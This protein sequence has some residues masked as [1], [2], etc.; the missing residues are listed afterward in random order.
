[1]I[2]KRLGPLGL[3]L[4]LFFL[5]MLMIGPLSEWW[6]KSYIKAGVIETA[7]E[8]PI[9]SLFGGTLLQSAA[10]KDPHVHVVPIYGSSEFGHGGPYNPTKLFAG[11]PTGWTPYLVGHAGSVDLIQ[12][13]YAGAQNLKG[14]KIV[15]SLSAQWF[16][17]NGVSQAT[18]GANF[19]ALQAYKMI[20]NPALTLQTKQAL[21]RRLIQFNEVKK[22]YPILDGFLNYYGQRDLKSLLLESVYWPAARVEMASLEIQDALKTVQVIQHL[23]AGKITDNSRSTAQ[24]VLPTWSAMQEKATNDVRKNETNNPFAVGNSFYSQRIKNLQSLKNSATK[25]HF[26]PSPEY[27]DLNLLMEVLKDE[28][29]DPIF[30]IQPVNGLWYDFTGFP[31]EQRQRYYSH[32]REMA[33]HFGFSLADFSTHEYDKYFMDDPSHPSEKGWLEFDE[34]LD[35]FVQQ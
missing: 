19:S 12:T 9:P 3:A 18:F 17:G 7:S 31:K 23:P 10:L 4:I 32:V 29:A 16:S 1:M 21:A 30:L 28:G 20:F 35:T 15:L 34:A 2:R 25:G 13:L 5:S 6:V 22:T 33:K 11:Q 26:Y 14:R 8:N 27:A 24:K